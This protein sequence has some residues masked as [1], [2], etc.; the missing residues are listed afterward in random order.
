M[1]STKDD[2]V[3]KYVEFWNF[4]SQ[5]GVI[6][7]A[8]M[9]VCLLW[10]FVKCRKKSPEQ[11]IFDVAMGSRGDFFKMFSRCS[12]FIICTIIVLAYL[13]SGEATM[14]H[15]FE[16]IPTHYIVYVFI[17]MAYDA[18]WEVVGQFTGVGRH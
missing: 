3:I 12:I 17:F 18:F 9:L 8:A 14:D 2:V 5:T 11:S 7:S 6:M 10:L 13:T 16:Q 1:G 15:V 4:T